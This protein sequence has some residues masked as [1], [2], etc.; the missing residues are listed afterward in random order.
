MISDESVIGAEPVISYEVDTGAAA[1]MRLMQ[2]IVG[3]SL[4][5][6]IAAITSEVA[7][8]AAYGIGGVGPALASAAG[9]IGGAV[10]NYILNR[11]W[12]WADRRG[13]GRRN[14]ILLYAAVALSSYGAS[15]LGTRAAEHWARHLTDD[16]IWRVLLVGAAYLAVSGVFFVIKFVLYHFAVFTAE[17]GSE[18]RTLRPETVLPTRL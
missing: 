17:P 15:V 13:R 4:G 16:H 5:S 12:A 10:P 9:F 1:P 11:R 3:Y 8:L 7:F 18:A 2:R 14:E 6:V